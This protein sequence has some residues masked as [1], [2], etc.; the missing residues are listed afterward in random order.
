MFRK[1][2]VCLERN[3][4]WKTMLCHGRWISILKDCCSSRSEFVSSEDYVHRQ[5]NLRLG[6]LS[7]NFTIT[8]H[9]F[10]I[11]AI[12]HRVVDIWFMVISRH[13]LILTIQY[14]GIVYTC[15][16]VWAANKLNFACKKRPCRSV[17][18][19]V[20]FNVSR[21]RAHNHLSSTHKHWGKAL[22]ALY[23]RPPTR[24]SA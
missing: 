10:L 13:V 9:Y 15:F 24:P 8:S 6:R 22:Y 19:Y 20:G 14:Q 23:P 18:G 2:F 12:Q 4:V 21:D 5:A 3:C 1:S 11:L 16:T 17:F 7:C